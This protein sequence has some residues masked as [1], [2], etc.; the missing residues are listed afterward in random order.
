MIGEDIEGVVSAQWE[1]ENCG[2]RNNGY[3]EL[4]DGE[5]AAYEHAGEYGHTVRGE[6][7]TMRKIEGFQEE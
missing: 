4:D 1:C 6:I 2:W 3:K 5:E 7:V